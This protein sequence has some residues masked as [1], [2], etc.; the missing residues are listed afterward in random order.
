MTATPYESARNTCRGEESENRKKDLGVSAAH[1]RGLGSAQERRRG[2]CPAS[3]SAANHMPTIMIAPETTAIRMPI[4]Q[5]V[6]QAD[7]QESDHE[8]PIGDRAGQPGEEGVEGPPLGAEGE[9]LEGGGAAIG[10]G[11]VGGGGEA[12]PEGLVDEGP[13]EHP[14]EG[15]SG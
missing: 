15:D 4:P 8:Q 10:P 14:P 12:Q 9:E 6:R 7:A 2:A 5:E 11:T 13:Q 3:G 1:R